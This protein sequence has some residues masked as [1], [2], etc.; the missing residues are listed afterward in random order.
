MKYESAADIRAQRAVANQ[1]ATLFNAEAHE[2]PEFFSY[3]FTL[4]KDGQCAGFLEVKRRKV[5]SSQYPDVILS[6][7]KWLEL[8]LL[9][10]VTGKPVFLVVQYLDRACMVRVDGKPEIRIGGRTDRGGHSDVEPVV[11]IPMSEM[12]F[13]YAGV[14]SGITG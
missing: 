11:A 12:K 14:A 3:D 4:I 5:T 6:L 10:K 2:T 1:I 13:A 9:T 7:N 8:S